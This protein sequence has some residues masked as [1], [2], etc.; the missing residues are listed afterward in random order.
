[1]EPDLEQTSPETGS[2]GLILTSD[3]AGADGAGDQAGADG[4]A[5]DTGKAGADDATPADGEPKAKDGTDGEP[6]DKPEEPT[7]TDFSLPEGMELDKAGLDQAVPIFKELGLTQDQAQKLVS[8]Y[9]ERV[10]ETLRSYTSQWVETVQSWGTQAKEDKEIGGE[11]FGPSVAAAKA[12]LK[13]HGTPELAELLAKHG[14]A[15]HPEIIRLLARV[16]KAYLTEDQ[17]SPARGSGGRDALSVMYPTM[18]EQ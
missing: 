8:F 10:G 2:E 16:G 6:G 15:N 11:A 5:K 3:P 9:A 14:Y 1:M 18:K 7:Y 13:A 17:L 4:A 12:V